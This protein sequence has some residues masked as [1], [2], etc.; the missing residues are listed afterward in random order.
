MTVTSAIDVRRA[1]PPTPASLAWLIA[2]ASTVTQARSPAIAIACGLPPT[3]IVDTPR[4][5]TGSIRVT[6]PSPLFA[7]QTDPAPTV[8]PVGDSPTGIVAVTDLVS[9]SIRM[10]VL[11]PVS[12]TQTAPSPTA[13]PLGPWP[14]ESAV[15][16]PVES[17]R[18]TLSASLSVSQT[19]SAPT[20][21]PAGPAF[22][23]TWPTTRP[24]RASR[25]VSSP[26]YGATQS[27]WPRA[28]SAVALPGTTLP[29]VAV[30]VI[31]S[32]AGSMRLTEADVALGL[33]AATH[34]L[35]FVAA[36]PVGGSGAG[37]VR[38]VRSVLGSTREIVSSSRFATHSEP[39]P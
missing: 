29:T 22:G 30:R 12:A 7:T 33:D 11:S 15:T 38:S 14:T 21:S 4:R 25:R 5:A 27:V 17:T 13:M 37:R 35:P 6:V 39:D 28:A 16:R 24:V 23:S 31:A 26:E 9:G 34:T 19:P 2:G 1:V 32:N 36:I 20:A 3:L 8:T 18:V 10:T